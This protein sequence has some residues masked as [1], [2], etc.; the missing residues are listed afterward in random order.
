MNSRI[1]IERAIIAAI[2]YNGGY[3]TV[4]SILQK[5]NFSNF[6]YTKIYTAAGNLYPLTPIDLITIHLELKKT[7]PDL[8]EVIT[9]EMYTSGKYLIGLHL[10]Y[11]CL[12]IL[13]LDIR[14]SFEKELITWR[15]NRIREK[16]DVEAAVLT[17]MLEMI[18]IPQ[19]DILVFIEKAISYFDR[20]DMSW[21]YKN[22]KEFYDS[23]GQKAC[24]IRRTI[25]LDTALS[26]AYKI[27]DCSS[28][29]KQTCDKFIGAINTM[30]ITNQ[31]KP[32]YS[33]AAEFL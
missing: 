31:V 21:E 22:S 7:D 28:D 15:D 13:Q 24:G 25:S 14:D 3:A 11:W 6:I 1:E 29:I 12:I 23:I 4:S 17:E 33:K 9:E 18:R 10:R 30:I 20:Q 26:A 16:E 2:V 32:E 19:L 27:S 8:L 5:K